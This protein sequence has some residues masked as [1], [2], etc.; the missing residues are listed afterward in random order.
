MATGLTTG[1]V[2]DHLAT[3]VD[4]GGGPP[5]RQQDCAFVDCLRE[6]VAAYPDLTAV[7]LR[8][9]IRERGCEGAYTAVKRFVVAI[10]P[11]D[12][13]RHA[14]SRCGSRRRPDLQKLLRISRQNQGQGRA[15]FS[16]YP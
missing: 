4:H 7:R 1:L 16:P 11:E 5:L 14:T 15:I 13:V 10:R 9:E 6:R 3:G 12:Q 8:R 2:A